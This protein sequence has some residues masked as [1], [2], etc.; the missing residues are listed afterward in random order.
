MSV[1]PCKG[2][3]WGLLLSML[4]GLSA[5]CASLTFKRGASPE[6]LRSDERACRAESS[7]DAGYGECMRDRGAFVAGAAGMAPGG[8]GAPK[9]VEPPRGDP[10]HGVEPAP[11]MEQQAAPAIAPPTDSE[12]P[13]DPLALVTISSWWK[14]GASGDA[15]DGAI[16]TCASE[17]GETHRPAKGAANVTVGL[18][19][20]LRKAGWYPLGAR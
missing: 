8:D 1:M 14:L 19:E 4:L 7:D 12:E 2:F 17:L 3:S 20:C 11:A 16:D 15:L 9:A 5:G 6:A 10:M 13:L 18:R